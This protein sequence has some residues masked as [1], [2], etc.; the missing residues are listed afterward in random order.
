MRRLARR[1]LRATARAFVEAP[2]PE[3]SKRDSIVLNRR[4]AKGGK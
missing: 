4:K 1:D 2:D 3:S